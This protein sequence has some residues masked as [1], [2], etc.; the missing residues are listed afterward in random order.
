MK[1]YCCEK[2]DELNSLTAVIAGWV[3]FSTPSGG[4]ITLCPNCSRATNLDIM[5][6]INRHRELCRREEIVADIPYREVETECQAI[7][8]SS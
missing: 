3:P 6:A 8:S 7:L 5:N 4:T 2:E 1:C